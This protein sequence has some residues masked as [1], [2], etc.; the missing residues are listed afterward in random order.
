MRELVPRVWA[1]VR[2]GGAR[3]HQPHHRCRGGRPARTV[4]RRVRGA[5]G[6]GGAAP[7][8]VAGLRPRAAGLPDARAGTDRA[9]RRRS[10]ASTGIRLM[11]RLVKGA[12]WDAE[13]KRAQELGLPHYPV[14]THKHHTDISYLA[15]ARALLDAQDVIYPA[16]RHAQRGTIAA[17]VQMATRTGA[18]F[19][20]QRLH[21][22]GEGIYREVLQN[23]LLA[24]RVYAPVGQHRDLLAYL[25]RRLLENGANS[26]FVHQL[27]D[28]SVGMDE[29]LQSPLHLAPEPSL[30]LPPDLYGPQPPPTAPGWTSPFPPTA[31]R[32]RR[33]WRRPLFPPSRADPAEMP[34][35]SIAPS[36]RAGAWARLP[37][38]T[39][40]TS[41]AAPRTPCRRAAAPVRVAGEGRLQDLGRRACRRCARPSTSCAT[42]PWRRSGCCSRSPCPARPA[43]A[44]CC[45]SPRAAL[46][47]HQP[48][49]FPARHLHRPGGR[50]AGHRQH[51]AGEAGGA[52][53]CHRRG[54]GP[55]A[56]RRRR[57]R[58]YSEL[59][60]VQG[61]ITISP[62]TCG[63]G[64][65]RTASSAIA[66][67]CSAGLASTGVAGGERRGHLP[68]EDRQ[69]E[70][71]RADAGPGA[72]RVSDA[73]RCS[74]RWDRAA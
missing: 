8:A 46:G 35:P 40:A 59:N 14:F 53:A 20:L 17:I 4:A 23:P 44:T 63:G 55:P 19:E 61:N 2:A 32:C 41:C 51:R 45:A 10:R 50:G 54:S 42:T 16:V 58:R 60:Q 52:D 36:S 70:F 24:C 27:A 48:L 67:V 29:L 38:E 34:R 7:S 47:V 22:M 72:A 13:I 11:C 26:S 9:R 64:G 57:A 25:V 6:A 73:V 33:H 18:P 39:R 5:G 66:G 37:A 15:C 43:K 68:G 12:Y 1:P 74:R 31:R 30:P 21:G 65:R 3:Q 49:E 56:A 69:R 62:A 28:E 71:P